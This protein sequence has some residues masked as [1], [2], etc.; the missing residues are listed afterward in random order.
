MPEGSRVMNVDAVGG[1]FGLELPDARRAL[2]DGA[3]PFQSARAAFLALLQALRPRAVW[4]PWYVCDSILEPLRMTG[5]PIRRY[6]LDERFRV[7]SVDLEAGEW[8]FYVDYFGLCDSNVDD[9]L[10]RFPRD[11]IVIDRS[12]AFY[13]PPADCLATLY[14]PRKFFG[15]PDGGYLATR[16]AIAEPA[17][18]DN[19]SV[20]RFAHLLKRIDAH[21]EAGFADYVAAEKTLGMQEPKRMSALTQRL[22]DSID[23]E[24][25]RE[26]RTR[27]YALLDAKLGA[28]NRFRYRP[29]EVTAPL[30]YPFLGAPAELRR[31]LIEKRIYTPGYWPEV[32]ANDS[33]PAFE[34]NVAASAIFLPCDQR[35]A[36]QQLD[37][38]SQQLL[39]AL[40]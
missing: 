18:V 14:S 38:V 10:S 30:C 40:G 26:R 12:Q 5:I 17:E 29:G 2:H 20:D 4:M 21:A 11:Q 35:L 16:C 1:Y 24:T 37:S 3:L 28:V 22:L 33:A 6:A 31:T 36:P 23:Y 19:G 15:V 8:L 7:A 9:V 34:R 25:I 39:H 27:N 13:A 32:A